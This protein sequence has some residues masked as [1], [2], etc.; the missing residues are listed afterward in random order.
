M[1]ARL[2]SLA[3]TPPR[4]PAIGAMISCQCLPPSV[5]RSS[6]PAA[7]AIQQ[8]FFAGAEPLVSVAVTG[9]S[10]DFH[11]LPPS[12]E[13]AIAPCSPN[14]QLLFSFDA[15]TMRGGSIAG[16]ITLL[17]IAGRLASFLFSAEISTVSLATSGAAA[18]TVTCCDGDAGG[19]GGEGGEAPGARF[20]APLAC[21]WIWLGCTSAP[22]CR[23]PPATPDLAASR[24]FALA[25]FVPCST[26]ERPPDCGVLAFAA[27]FGVAA[28]GSGNF[29]SAFESLG[30]SALLRNLSSSS[31][32][33][34]GAG[35]AAC[36]LDVLA[37][38]SSSFCFGWFG[39]PGG[40]VCGAFC[41]TPGTASESRK[42]ELS[43]R[44]SAVCVAGSALFSGERK[45]RRL[46]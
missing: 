5:V 17:D 12:L 34:R 18:V 9:T 45:S 11:V 20:A 16:S 14:L 35:L 21:S 31:S 2:P 23:E 38:R 1:V 4:S 28:S 27:L 41:G 36:C 24:P 30:D 42:F 40:G 44:F 6:V 8:M 10:C 13:C 22:F 25:G 33:T 15:T 32:K 39:V 3:I 43:S 29:F 37:A 7:P 46:A 26:V 19:T